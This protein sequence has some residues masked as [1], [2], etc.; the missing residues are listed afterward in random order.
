MSLAL[1]RQL[2]RLGQ[3]MRLMVSRGV[4]DAVDDS[5]KCQALRMSLLADEVSEDVEHF[6]DYGYTSV[7][8][9]DAEGLFFAVGGDRAHG[10]VLGV[11]DRGKR[12]LNLAAGDVCLYT[13]KG[14][15]VYLD[16]VADVVRLGSK[17]GAEFLVQG[18]TFRTNQTTM[19]NALGTGFTNT[20]GALGMVAIALGFTTTA[21]VAASLSAF[22]LTIANDAAF[23]ATYPG[24]AGGAAA[25]KTVCD[26]AAAPLAAA[27]TACTYV[28]TQN[29]NMAG[30]VS[31]FESGG[32]YLSTKTATE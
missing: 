17:T 23:V 28:G 11:I 13:D 24:I 7:P 10:V 27:A 2:R 12:P 3:K 5:K 16:R 32:N 26:N 19:N 29:T 4:V 9:Q 1:T 25:L 14:E 15:R 22:C 30:A 31:T 21:L 18:T 8:F 6:Q 20:A